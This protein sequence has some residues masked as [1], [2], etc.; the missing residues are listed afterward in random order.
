MLIIM[1]IIWLAPFAFIVLQS[2]RCESTWMVGYVI[3][4][5]WGL[6]DD[7]LDVMIVTSEPVLPGS[8]I[9]CS[10]IGM[11]EMT[12]SGKEDQKVIAVCLDDPIYCDYEDLHQLPK[13]LFEEIRHCNEIEQ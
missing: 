11:L 10:P 5:T 8:L 7:P 13:H 6:D 4:K 12:D 9:R 1:S 2:F 3:P